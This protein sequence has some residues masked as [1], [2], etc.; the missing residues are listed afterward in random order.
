M[1][2]CL[3]NVEVKYISVHCVLR[4]C[5]KRAFREIIIGQIGKGIF[6]IHRNLQ[7]LYKDKNS[8]VQN[9]KIAVTYCIT[10]ISE[11]IFVNKRDTNEQ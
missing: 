7:I 8:K 5:K 11:D 10:I 2:N 1:V 6:L 3:I 9:R 4:Q